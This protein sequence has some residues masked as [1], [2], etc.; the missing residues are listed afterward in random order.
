MAKSSM[1]SLA[2]LPNV[3]V[4][5]KSLMY[6]A[7]GR[8]DEG[9]RA[10]G[11]T[12][13]DK[14]RKYAKIARQLSKKTCFF[15]QALKA[16]SRLK[17]NNWEGYDLC[18]CVLPL[19]KGYRE[20]NP[21]ENRLAQIPSLI[22]SGALDPEMIAYSDECIVDGVRFNISFG[23]IARSYAKFKG[24]YVKAKRCLACVIE[25]RKANKP[26]QQRVF[27]PR[28]N[29]LVAASD[30]P[31][32]LPPTLQGETIPPISAEEQAKYD[33]ALRIRNGGAAQKQ[34]A[35]SQQMGQRRGAAPK[36]RWV[37]P[38]KPRGFAQPLSA[39]IAEQLAAKHPP[40]E[41]DVPQG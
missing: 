15:C 7:Q 18:P 25:Q 41:K 37:R 24:K 19:A 16:K 5:K 2:S 4:L 11:L 23:M 9:V 26:G 35:A 14:I 32:A 13:T 28:I 21:W 6:V 39:P 36:K 22:E 17:E 1:V 34:F 3:D 20:H 38:G 29:Q 31:P 27:V 30:A 10:L 12:S 8:V 33:E 40:T